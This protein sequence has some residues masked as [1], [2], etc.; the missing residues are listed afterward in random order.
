M[1]KGNKAAVIDWLDQLTVKQ[2]AN[3]T[4]DE[5]LSRK[6][7]QNI[8][9]LFSAAFVT[10][11]DAETMTRNP[12]KGV[13]EADLNEAGEAVYLSTEDLVMLAER[14]DPHYSL[15]IRFLGGTGLRRSEATALRRRDITI[16]DG[17]AA[18][19]V[20]RAWKSKGKGEEIGPPKTKKAN[21]TVTCNA[22]LSAAL[23][24]RLQEIELDDFVFQRPDGDYVR[25]SRFHKEVWQP[26]MGELVGKELDRKPWI[27]EIRHAHT[28]HLLDANVPV[29]VVQAR[30]G[31]EDPQTTLR[32]YA[33]LAKASD[34]AAA[35]ALG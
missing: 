19:R 22:T 31:H 29:H 17:R 35:D 24:D 5:P 6:T 34:A 14:I 15:L 18:V 26:L 7:K 16:R 23:A 21:R 1:D 32:V 9:A 25:N 4:K 30:L 11:M 12:A 13:A 27:H 20:S 8:H 3:Q 28:T 10:A 33:R 2:G